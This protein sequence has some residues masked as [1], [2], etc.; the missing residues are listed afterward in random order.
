MEICH[1]LSRSG[2]SRRNHSARFHSPENSFQCCP[3]S[4]IPGGLLFFERFVSK[5]Y[6]FFQALAYFFLDV[7]KCQSLPHGKLFQCQCW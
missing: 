4:D 6:S 1:K 5:W 3:G 7:Y 2:Q